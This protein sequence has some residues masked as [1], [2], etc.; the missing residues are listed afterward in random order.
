MI[1]QFLH[2]HSGVGCAASHRADAATCRAAWPEPDVARMI[3]RIKV[4]IARQL[5]TAG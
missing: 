5:A 3:E 1:R 4:F 2:V